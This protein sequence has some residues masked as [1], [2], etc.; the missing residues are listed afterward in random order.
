MMAARPHSPARLGNE[1]AFQQIF[2]LFKDTFN[3]DTLRYVAA[4]YGYDGKWTRIKT[5]SQILLYL[6][7]TF[8]DLQTNSVPKTS[9]IEQIRIPFVYYNY[10]SVF[11]TIYLLTAK[12]IACK[13]IKIVGKMQDKE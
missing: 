13:Q 12:K 3:I 2:D 7:S 1:E 5:M 8:A 9:R 6:V 10:T 4:S 11:L